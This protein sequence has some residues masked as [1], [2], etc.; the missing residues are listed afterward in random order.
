[1]ARRSPRTHASSN[2]PATSSSKR[3]ADGLVRR[4]ARAATLR[5]AVA[6]PVRQLPETDHGKEDQAH[7]EHPENDVGAFTRSV[8]DHAATLA[9]CKASALATS[10]SDG[11]PPR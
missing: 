10:S 9:K 11:E 2:A 7:D 4:R 6:G 3:S 5:P 8:E 1:P